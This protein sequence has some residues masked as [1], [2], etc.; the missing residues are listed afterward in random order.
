[1]TD[2]RFLRLVLA[3]STTG[4]VLRDPLYVAFRFE[5]GDEQIVA[6]WPYV[7]DCVPCS[8]RELL[9]VLHAASRYW[10]GLGH[11]MDP[12]EAAIAR[13]NLEARRVDRESVS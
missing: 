10:T 12:F 3:D 13:A 2:L 4:V 7:V 5:D 8:W 1:M 9:D 11:T 6:V